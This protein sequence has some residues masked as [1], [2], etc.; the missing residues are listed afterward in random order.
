MC[1][2]LSVLAQFTQARSRKIYL[3]M[4]DLNRAILLKMLWEILYRRSCGTS[5]RNFVL[6]F[7]AFVWIFDIIFFISAK[8][9]ES[10]LLWK[11]TQ[12]GSLGRGE[13]KKVKR[14]HFNVSRMC[15]FLVWLCAWLLLK[16]VICNIVKNYFWQDKEVNNGGSSRKRFQFRSK[17]GGEVKSI[18]KKG[19]RGWMILD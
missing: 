3:H 13:A 9:A 18:L 10:I 4:L 8:M 17:S 11:R 14:V 12:S 15:S 19:K 2:N 16:L 7:W 6:K 5:S 1:V